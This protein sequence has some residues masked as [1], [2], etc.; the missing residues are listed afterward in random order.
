MTQILSVMAG[1]ITDEIKNVA[2]IEQ[3]PIKDITD[4]IKGGRIVIPKNKKREIEN[5]KGIGRG[6]LKKVNANI[7]VSPKA[8]SIKQEKEKL[9][10]ALDAGADTIMDLSIGKN[11]DKIRR[12][13][14]LECPVPFGTVPIYQ[15]A[16]SVKH[17][18]DIS[19]SL[20]LEVIEKQASDGVDFMTIHCG[21]TLNLCSDI[22]KRLIPIVSRGGAIIYK[23]M[24][25]NKAENPFYEYFNDI[26]KIALKYDITL[27]L[28]DSL[29]PGCLADASHPSQIKEL[30]TLGEL[31]DIAHNEGIQV[32]IE[33]PGHLPLNHIHA[34]VRLAK[35]IT[36]GAPLY[37]LG[38]I[39]IDIACGYDHIAS[40]IGGA[41]AALYGADFICY[42]T[43][44][45][46]LGLPTPDDVKM[47]VIAARIAGMCAD[48]ALGKKELLERNR[49][50]SIARKDLNWKRQEALALDPLKLKTYCLKNNTSCTMC[51][52]FCVF[53]LYE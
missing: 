7:G 40:A 17:I 30:I 22:E 37:L 29:R 9:K 49:K 47:G 35:E 43:P 53:K 8:S 33:G 52:N 51:G 46:H 20:I 5:I 18:E 6:L 10:A 3:L 19:K 2:E 16:C 39:P 50:M 15:A 41:Y 4:G 12:E 13:L 44:S 26:L 42:V 21:L 45:E 48:I 27:S 32:I 25:K 1:I 31:K 34:N 24:K 11:I 14:L 23:W 38:P 36:K 28:G